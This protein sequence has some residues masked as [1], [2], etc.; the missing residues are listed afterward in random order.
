MPTCNILDF[1]LIQEY[2]SENVSD[3][4]NPKSSATNLCC[5]ESLPMTYD[6]FVLGITDLYNS[7]CLR[8]REFSDYVTQLFTECL[9]GSTGGVTKIIAGT[10]ITISP[11]SGLGDVTI[12]SSGSGGGYW[13]GNT[14]GTIS[15]SGLTSTNI[16][17]GTHVPSEMLSVSGNTNITNN[18]YVTGNT[19]YE[20]ALSGTG[21]ITTLGAVTTS[22]V[23][24]PLISNAAGDEII[25]V[26][27]IGIDVAGP[28]NTNDN[29]YITGNTFYEG[30]LS[31]TGNIST[32][33][34]LLVSGDT[35]FGSTVDVGIDGTGHDVIFY[36]NTA[37]R[38]FMWDTSRSSLNLND[39]TRLEIG[40]SSDF[41]LWHDAS[42]NRIMLQAHPL[43]ITTG[44]TPGDTV[45]LINAEQ[46]VGI[47]TQ[48]GDT[49]NRLHVSGTSTENPA[50]IQ[51]LQN[52]EGSIVVIDDEGILY[53]SE[54]SSESVGGG[55]LW[56]GG[57]HD[58]QP[59]IVASGGTE[60]NIGIGT[61]SPNEI[62]T[63]A[64]TISADTSIFVGS[65]CI[66]KSP[67][68]NSVFI[69]DD[70]GA[71]WEAGST[72][73][74]ALGR[75]AMGTGTMNDAV[76]NTALGFASLNYI[77]TGTRNTAV[78]LQA[79]TSIDT[80]SWN[81]SIGVTAMFGS[82]YHS[83]N[84]AVG[85]NTMY[86][87]TSSSL[88]KTVIT[89]THNTA[90]G[91]SSQY[92]NLNGAYNTSLGSQS[93]GNSSIAYAG[94]GSTALGFKSLFNNTTGNYNTTVGYQA[95]DNITTGD[96]N[97]SI[98]PDA[99]PPSATADYQMN[100]GNIIY[101][102]DV[103]SSSSINSI[104]I[105][106]HEPTEKLTVSGNTNISSNLFVSGDTFYEGALSGTGNIVTVGNITAGGSIDSRGLTSSQ[107]LYVIGNTYYEGQLSG[108]GNI[109]TTET[110][111]G[112]NITMQGAGGGGTVQLMP[113]EDQSADVILTIP[114][115]GG[116]DEIVT[117]T[118]D[119]TLTDKTLTTPTIAQVKPDGSATLTMPTATDTLVGKAT[120]DTLTNK[121]MGDNLAMG[122]N[123]VTGVGDPTAAQDAATKN[124]IDTQY[125]YQYI[126]FLGNTGAISDDDWVFPG[127]NGISNHTWSGGVGGADGLITGSS[128]ISIARTIQHSF[129][130][131]PAGAKL[132][133]LEGIIRSNTNDQAYGGLFTFLPDYEGPDSKDATLR[134]LAQT[135]S[136][137]NNVTNDPQTMKS[138]A[139]ETHM[140][141]FADGECIIPALRRDSSSSQSLLGSFTIILKT[142]IT[143]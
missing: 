135:P 79:N 109:T 130:R 3:P 142:L 119:E 28:I 118:G 41:A 31:G 67:E 50:R 64:G 126:S 96:Y 111:H 82:T 57:T 15:N 101:G 30:A 91:Y 49:T 26:N 110:I 32:T 69:G 76:Q 92:Y 97:I 78:G 53:K 73:N 129:I 108:T 87:T 120:T 107:N 21:S 136:S 95:G 19:F 48:S 81:T 52:S 40:T 36:S 17:I 54:R 65:D 60:P 62:L 105:G 72:S 90:V 138:W 63:V 70:A 125:T 115:L 131:V 77:T 2:Y 83:C 68:T 37:D 134:L 33:D 46:Q 128:T 23:Q 8:D 59:T 18:L 58:D 51:T 116:N 127:T 85:A 140:H 61:D 117:R 4:N 22:N 112:L 9:S 20:G 14:D 27:T 29:L 93:I 104:G 71:N 45:M 55:G 102:K 7:S 114:L 56:T 137:S 13:T 88:G 99:D 141:T 38:K 43:T 121:T 113:N 39:E 24:T 100:I 1:S 66:I 44:S 143:S 132:V 75:L 42:T 94:T 106:T 34:S 47:G 12:N 103:G 5:Y 123:K 89:D 11:T 80:G 10:N 25:S 84:T 122:T 16:G 35:Y 124:Y 133:A 98:G 139:S 74:T 6:A 86:F